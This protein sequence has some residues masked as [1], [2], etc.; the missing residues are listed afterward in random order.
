MDSHGGLE[1]S[2][3]SGLHLSKKERP[4][5]VCEVVLHS[6]KVH[7]LEPLFSSY[8]VSVNGNGI[9]KLGPWRVIKI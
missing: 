9:W 3:E 1:K 8:R 6:P 5:A 2:P 7:V 4:C